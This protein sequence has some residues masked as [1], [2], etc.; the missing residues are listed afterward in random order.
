MRAWI[1]WPTASSTPGPSRCTGR[2]CWA[3]PVIGL[4]ASA[5]SRPAEEAGAG[6]AG[7]RCPARRAP[8]SIARA[9]WT[10]SRSRRGTRHD[11]S[12][13]LLYEG[14]HPRRWWSWLFLR[15]TSATSSPALPLSVI[16]A[17]IGMHSL[18]FHQR[19]HLLGRC[20]RWSASWWTTPS[21]WKT[22]CTTCAWARMPGQGAVGEAS[23]METYLVV[24]AT[25]FTPDR[26]V[27]AHVLHASGIA[28]R[29]NGSPG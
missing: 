1:S 16:P 15:P 6:A 18:G 11:S 29:S 23:T 7:A 13:H 14:A 3:T 4:R 25:T 5:Q 9:P 17:F 26:R 28:G 27:P 24:I 19:H 22:S 10:L 12:M 8:A 2:A 21:R 20:R